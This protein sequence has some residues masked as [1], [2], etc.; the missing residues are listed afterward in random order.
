MPAPIFSLRVVEGLVTAG[1]P[2]I[3]DTR[4]RKGVDEKGPAKAAELGQERDGK[5]DG[6]CSV[7]QFLLSS[8]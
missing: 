1:S 7:G 2:R 5:R 8:L 6:A 3:L 4:P